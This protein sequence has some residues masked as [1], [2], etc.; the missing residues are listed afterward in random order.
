MNR[1]T[2]FTILLTVAV[3]LLWVT[4][5]SAGVIVN[6]SV[7]FE[8]LVPIPCAGEAV[9]LMG[10]LHTL[11]TLT[12]DANGG[13]HMTLHFQPQNVS[14]VGIVSGD[15]YRGTGVTRET[16]NTD[17]VAMETTFVNNFRI[18]GQGTGNNLLVHAVF[19]MTVN[20]NGDVTAEVD[21]MS[22]ECM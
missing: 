17:T 21:L 12:E 11:I 3:A 4:P 9:L 10:E 16:V 19:H 13:I 15:M 8:V 2:P 14:G 7:P 5:A 1:K 22:S 20:A 18:I 6:E